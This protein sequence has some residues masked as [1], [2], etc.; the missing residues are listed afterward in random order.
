MKGVKV[1]GL[2]LVIICVLVAAVVGAEEAQRKADESPDALACPIPVALAQRLV[3][4]KAAAEYKTTCA[5]LIKGA[6]DAFLSEQGKR[7][8]E[9]ERIYGLH[10]RAVTEP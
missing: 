3:V 5:Q 9:I 1:L 10:Q 2:A 4:A 8:A 6:F 7:Q